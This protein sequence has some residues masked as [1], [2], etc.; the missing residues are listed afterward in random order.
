MKSTSSGSGLRRLPRERLGSPVGDEAAADLGLDLG[1]QLLDAGV[2]LIFQQALLEGGELAGPSPPQDRSAGV[3]VVQLAARTSTRLGDEPGE[4][5]LQVEMTKRPVKVISPPDRAPRLHGGVTRHGEAGD[6]AQQQLVPVAKRAYHHGGDLFSRGR[7]GAAE[8]FRVLAVRC[9]LGSPVLLAE[10][11]SFPVQEKLRTANREVDLEGG[12]EGPP[13]VGGLNQ[14]GAEGGL[15]C[16]AV[17][18]GELSHRLGR[19][20]LLGHRYRKP[21]L[22]QFGHETDEDVEH[23]LGLPR[24][25]PVSVPGRDSE[26]FRRHLDVRAVLEQDVERGPGR[27]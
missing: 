8:A 11:R 27:L 10:G 14:G 15:Y 23:A 16:L 19:V 12:V 9:R 13:V 18:K 20:H 1:L 7:L 2:V 24:P 21:E 6:G 3:F 25:E 22:A 4:R 5:A 26:L 17:L